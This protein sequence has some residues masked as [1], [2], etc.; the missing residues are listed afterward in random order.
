MDAGHESEANPFTMCRLSF[1]VSA[2]A[3]FSRRIK[4]PGYI[5]SESFLGVMPDDRQGREIA[6]PVNDRCQE[7]ASDCFFYE[8]TKKSNRSP[9]LSDFT[10][11]R[12]LNVFFRTLLWTSGNVGDRI[13]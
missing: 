10:T 9:A 6:H 3:V 5:F 4:L 2:L 8:L 1:L 13:F 12:Y 11:I 7:K